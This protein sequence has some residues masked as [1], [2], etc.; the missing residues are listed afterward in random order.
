MRPLRFFRRHT[1][2][3]TPIQSRL[4]VLDDADQPGENME[5]QQAR[6]NAAFDRVKEKDKE[7]REPRIISRPA[8]Q[9]LNPYRKKHIDA[10][11]VESFIKEARGLN[12]SELLEL[13]SIMHWAG[14]VDRGRRPEFMNSLIGTSFSTL[15]TPEASND[16]SSKA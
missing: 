9:L 4:V 7:T 3:S 15:E 14:F 1:E 11:M 8:R 13:F 5:D 2:G 12:Q 16:Q 10:E 6:V